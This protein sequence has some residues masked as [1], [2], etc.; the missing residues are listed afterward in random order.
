VCKPECTDKE[1]GDDGCGGVCG[2]CDDG[3]ACVAAGCVD[4]AELECKGSDGPSA[5]DCSAF[6][7]DAACCDSTG[8]VWFCLLDAAYCL[9]CAAVN[10]HCGWNGENSDYDCGTDGGIDPA[11][12]LPK[13]C[14]EPCVPECDGKQCGD[15]GC[16]G[17]CGLCDDG[18]GC[19]EGMCVGLEEMECKGSQTPS[20]D[21]CGSLPPSGGCCDSD[22]RLWAC[23]NDVAYCLNCIGLNPQCGWNANFSY[24]DCGTDGGTDPAGIMPKWC[25]DGCFP[26]CQGKQCGDDGCGGSC[27]ECGATQ[28]CENNQCV[29]DPCIG[30]TPYGCCWEGNLYYCQNDELKGVDCSGNPSCGWD[31]GAGWYD[32]GTPGGA[33]P[34]GTHPYSC[35]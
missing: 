8:R 14:G 6:P 2:T 16:G 22:G 10:P 18:F 9:D 3:Y 26:D 19:V 5:D 30:I 32:C 29:D 15:D 23:V 11:G 13:W 7:G 34:S 4:F 17:S 21:D 31:A 33:D 12:L 24:Y 35:L 20:A 25:G 1:C 27:G 28:D